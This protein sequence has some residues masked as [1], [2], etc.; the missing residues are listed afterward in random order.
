MRVVRGYPRRREESRHLENSSKADST[1]ELDGGAAPL[2]IF[3]LA[4][5]PSLL[6]SE[7]RRASVTVSECDESRRVDLPRRVQRRQQARR[8]R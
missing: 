1:E 8:Q 6:D 3:G 2:P 5:D 7:Q 4:R